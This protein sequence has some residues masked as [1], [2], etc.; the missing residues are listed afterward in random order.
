M[1]IGSTLT[2]ALRYIGLTPAANGSVQSD[3]QVANSAA[4]AVCSAAE[5]L[6]P[7]SSN[8]AGVNPITI[9]AGA[10]RFSAR[11][12]YAIATT[13]CTTAP[14]VVFAATD[15]NGVP[16]RIDNID[17]DA[18]GTTLGVADAADPTLVMT[19]GTY[20]WSDVMTFTLPDLMGNATLYAL[21]KTASNYSGGTPG[22]QVWVKFLN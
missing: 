2:G 20:F 7:A 9:P 13:T 22:V 1:A 6:N 12:R 8:D 19:D 11:L 14:K 15:A 17:S 18:A 10:T 21:I 16:E 4:N 5:L 3:W